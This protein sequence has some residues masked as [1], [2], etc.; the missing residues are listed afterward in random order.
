MR[1]PSTTPPRTKTVKE[2]G[3]DLDTHGM[4]T[5]VSAMLGDEDITDSLQANEGS[6]VFLFRASGLDL[7]E[8]DLNRSVSHG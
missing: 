1:A 3:D 8:H 6:N 5:I 7:G 4:V 2:I